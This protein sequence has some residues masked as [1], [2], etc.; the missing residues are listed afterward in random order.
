MLDR[1]GFVTV[2]HISQF[3]MIIKQFSSEIFI[4]KIEILACQNQSF[5]I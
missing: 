3:E 5:S 1:S 2:H 4:Q